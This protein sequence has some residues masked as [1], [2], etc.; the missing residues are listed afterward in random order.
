MSTP[1]TL[2]QVEQTP[3][4]DSL[5]MGANIGWVLLSTVLVWLMI[6]GLG[7]FY[8]GLARR[9]NALSLVFIC[10]LSIPIVSLQWFVIG[11]SLAFSPTGGPFIGNFEHALLRGVVTKVY[12]NGKIPQLA[13]SIF[14]CM[15]AAFPPALI[16]GGSAERARTM[17]TLVFFV[18]WTTLVYDFI[19]YWC[20]SDN[21]W[22]ADLGGLDFAGGTPIHISSGAAALAYSYV[23]GP[24]KDI[25]IGD[26]RPHNIMNVILV[27]TVTNLAASIGGLTWMLIDYRFE[28]RFSV[29]GFCSGA[30]AGLVCVTPAA[31]YISISSSLLFGIFPGVICN[32]L[33][34]LRDRWRYD[35]ALDVFA[36]HGIGGALGSLLTGIFAQKEIALLDGFTRI[37]GGWL[38][39]NFIQLLYQLFVVL[40]GFGYSFVITLLILLAMDQIPVLKLRVRSNEEDDGIDRSELGEM[41]DNPQRIEPEMNDAD[42]R[43]I[44]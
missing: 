29:V 42:Q 28:H 43:A 2:Q 31:G 8:S 41:G 21:G 40:A 23:L 26:F 33:V 25:G 6:P 4:D 22:F 13:H 39:G 16:I 18:I 24:R 9:K 44:P 19:A 38:D 10:I 11:Y 36:I 32:I 17:P 34:K 1:P 7:F 12:K 3:L 15:F 30:L 14:Q 5:R 20:W 35:D 37:N 27:C